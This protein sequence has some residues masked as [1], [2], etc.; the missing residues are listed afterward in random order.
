[1]TESEWWR[2]VW[3]HFTAD[4]LTRF[5]EKSITAVPSQEDR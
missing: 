3:Q 2:F 4:E 1:M 5:F